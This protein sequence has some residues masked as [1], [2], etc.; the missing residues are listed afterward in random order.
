MERNVNGNTL[1]DYEIIAKRESSRVELHFSVSALNSIW[2]FW[3]SSGSVL[4]LDLLCAPRPPDFSHLKWEYSMSPAFSIRHPQNMLKYSGTYM[5]DNHNVPK[6]QSSIVWT[7]Q[8]PP[9]LKWHRPFGGLT[10]L[11]FSIVFNVLLANA[12]WWVISTVCID[13]H[14]MYF[15]PGG[16][17]GTATYGLYRYV[18]LWGVWFWSSFLWDRVYKSERLGLE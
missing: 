5:C 2:T 14:C 17:G 13:V 16:E 11:Q 3:S 18:P 9:S 12:K 7:T 8:E 4:V 10:V 1:L 6:L 15:A